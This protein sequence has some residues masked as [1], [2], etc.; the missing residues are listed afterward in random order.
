MSSALSLTVRPQILSATFLAGELG[1]QLVGVRG[2]DS[3]IQV[4]LPEP[5][6]V[7]EARSKM[8][9]EQLAQDGPVSQ[10]LLN[11][12]LESLWVLTEYQ[13]EEDQF[14][15]SQTAPCTS[16]SFCSLFPPWG[17]QQP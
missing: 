17:R 8:R 13:S 9:R 11:R 1:P 3:F 7:D 4:W 12:H 14:G 6:L 16:S 2:T 10:K 15:P 5:L